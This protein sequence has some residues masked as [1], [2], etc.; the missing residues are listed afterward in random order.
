MV[1]VLAFLFIIFVSIVTLLTLALNSSYR[2]LLFL[3]G[4][5]VLGISAT[6]SNGEPLPRLVR[7]SLGLKL[8][9]ATLYD[10]RT[11]TRDGRTTGT[12]FE[13]LRNHGFFPRNWHS[14]PRN[15][16]YGCVETEAVRFQEP[17]CYAKTT[18]GNR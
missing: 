10:H 4:F 13:P 11:R 16:Q 9:I 1:V 14:F 3:L 12:V 5:V 17:V 7:L 15:Q 2:L 8:N 18:D 6:S